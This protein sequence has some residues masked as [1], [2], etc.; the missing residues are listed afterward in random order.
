MVAVMF[1]S[2]KLLRLYDGYSFKIWWQ[3]HYRSS[4][5]THKHHD[6]SWVTH[7][8]CSGSDLLDGQKHW[9]TWFCWYGSVRWIIEMI[10]F[11]NYGDWWFHSPDIL[12][13]LVKSFL[14]PWNDSVRSRLV[15]KQSLFHLQWK[16]D[17]MVKSCGQF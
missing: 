3:N 1:V 15:Y 8:C 11:E 16:T 9:L 5:M 6:S 17:H 13:G 4:M 14:H 12:S 7:D 2:N 10:W